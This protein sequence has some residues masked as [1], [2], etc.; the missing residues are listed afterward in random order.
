MSLNA[1]ATPFVSASPYEADTPY[2]VEKH[3]Y[4]TPA[5][6]AFNNQV[7]QE[8]LTAYNAPPSLLGSSWVR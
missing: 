2:D 6:I 7:A 8:F 1:A 3:L 5:N 4:D